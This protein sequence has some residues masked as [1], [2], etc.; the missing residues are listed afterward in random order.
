MVK[1][2]LNV[3]TFP[4]LILVIIY[5]DYLDV[6]WITGNA[7]NTCGICFVRYRKYLQ[8]NS[9]NHLPILLCYW[10]PGKN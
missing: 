9:P 4:E 8:R 10:T 7:Y 1:Y 5:K 2:T 3:F 6:V